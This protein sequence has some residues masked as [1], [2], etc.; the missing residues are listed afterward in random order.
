MVCSKTSAT[1]SQATLA[2]R[3]ASRSQQ[4]QPRAQARALLLRL[5]DRSVSSQVSRL[6]RALSMIIGGYTRGALGVSSHTTASSMASTIASSF[7]EAHGIN[8]QLVPVLPLQFP[9]RVPP[10]TSIPVSRRMILSAGQWNS[11]HA[12]L[13]L[14]R[15]EEHTSELQS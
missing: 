10:T 15:S 3:P 9:L 11:L 8:R 14:E 12:L 6:V 1:C 2:R 7:L 13:L 4:P 5:V